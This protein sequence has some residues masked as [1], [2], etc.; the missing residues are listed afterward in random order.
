MNKVTT[1]NEHRYH[2]TENNYGLGNAKPH[3]EAAGGEHIKGYSCFVMQTLVCSG[4]TCRSACRLVAM[5]TTIICPA[6][7]NWRREQPWNE[8]SFQPPLRK[9]RRSQYVQHRNVLRAIVNVQFREG[10]LGGSY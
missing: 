5:V 2:N 8:T 4:H 3:T 7:K 1:T 9:Y 6:I 10:I